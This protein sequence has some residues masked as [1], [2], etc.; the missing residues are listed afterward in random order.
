MWARSPRLH[1]T[2]PRPNHP[3]DSHR[4]RDHLDTTKP[5]PV[6][7]APAS[8]KKSP[9]NRYTSSQQSHTHAPRPLAH[10][11]TGTPG[12]TRIPNLLIRSHT[13][14]IPASRMRRR[15]RVLGSA[16]RG[17]DSRFDPE[18]IQ[19]NHSKRSQINRT[20]MPQRAE[21]PA[22]ARVSAFVSRVELR[23]FEPLTP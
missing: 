7:G 8:T 23:G 4:E 17:E 1:S 5:S 22:V 3:R 21:T 2:E 18:N 10:G 12:G 20:H 16:C 14:F 15:W 13:A 19:E 9:R 6:V 11:F